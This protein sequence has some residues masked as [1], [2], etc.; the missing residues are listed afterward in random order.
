M[1]Y[2]A[3]RCNKTSTPYLQNPVFC[4]QP[5][6]TKLFVTHGKF[7]MKNEYLSARTA[8]LKLV[9]P[10][11]GSYSLVDSYMITGSSLLLLSS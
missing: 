11:P 6:S 7:F 1:G 5:G 10:Q 3:G 8:W 2:K 4:D 9:N